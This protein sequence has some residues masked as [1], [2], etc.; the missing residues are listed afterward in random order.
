MDS[1]R[2]WWKGNGVVRCGRAQT[3][4]TRGVMTADP[5][6]PHASCWHLFGAVMRRCREN[7]PNLALRRAASELYVDFSVRHE[8][9]FDRAEVEDH[10]P[11]TVAAVGEKLRAA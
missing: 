6:D 11:L 10:R 5:I 4:I 8:A 7:A 3:T 2:K 9:P 1:D